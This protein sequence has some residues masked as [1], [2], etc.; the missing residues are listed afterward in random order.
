M[1][2]HITN[3]VTW[4]VSLVGNPYYLEGRDIYACHLNYVISMDTQNG[5]GLSTHAHKSSSFP[6]L[7]EIRLM[8]HRGQLLL[9]SCLSFSILI[10]HNS[11]KKRWPPRHWSFT[12]MTPIEEEFLLLLF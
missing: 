11:N 1:D 3:C 10:I 9:S 12:G 8:S 5:H 7:F 6:S 2:N 4:I